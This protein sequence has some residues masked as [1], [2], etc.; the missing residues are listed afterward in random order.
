MT[1]TFNIIDARGLP[2]PVGVVRSLCN[3]G[4]A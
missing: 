3:G 4:T 2:G 1:A